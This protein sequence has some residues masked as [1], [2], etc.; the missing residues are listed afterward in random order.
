MNSE[1]KVKLLVCAHKAGTFLNDEH[2]MPIQVG[3]ALSAADLHIQGDDTGENISRKNPHYCELTALYWA[4]KNLKKTDYIGLCHYRRYFDFT[5]GL[6][7]E[8][9]IIR[10]G[11]LGKSQRLPVLK[12][13]F[14]KY[15]IILPIPM[16]FKESVRKHYDRCH[17][18]GDLEVLR[19]V[20]GELTPDYLEA[21]DAVINQ[22]NKLA[23][24]NMFLTGWDHFNRYCEWLFPVLSELEK[25]ID[26]SDDPYQSRIF[27][28]MGERLLNVY[29]RR[30][31][32]KVKYYPIALMDDEIT[33]ENGVWHY[34]WTRMKYNAIFHLKK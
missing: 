32:L 34:W 31:R 8:R 17:V 33:E 5:P 21:F 19:E 10:T 3:K 22:N 25:R 6:Y 26:I 2:Y 4:W 15:D 24:Y 29:C 28:F 1:V 14:R 27:G 7:R 13:L 12:K 18:G 11:Q 30:H 23:G 20:I 16:V 9:Y